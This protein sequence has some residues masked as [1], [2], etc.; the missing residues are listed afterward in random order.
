MIFTFVSF[1]G[2]VLFNF[3]STVPEEET[4]LSGFSSTLVSLLDLKL[5]IS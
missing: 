3:T 4:E 1:H 5:V 2:L